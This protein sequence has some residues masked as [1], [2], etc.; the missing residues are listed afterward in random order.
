MDLLP[1]LPLPLLLT[2]PLP[3][4]LTLPTAFS[5]LELYKDRVV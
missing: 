1:T 2:V 4:L 5:D 3:L